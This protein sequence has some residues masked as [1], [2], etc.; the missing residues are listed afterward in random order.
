MA[1]HALSWI[2][3]PLLVLLAASTSFAASRGAWAPKT[4]DP[5][6]GF[7][8]VSL[9]ES[10]FVLQRPF[11]EASG[12][13]YSFNGTVRKLWVL[14]SD[15][16]HARQSHTSP[17]TE[18]RMAGYD[19]SSGVW[20]F[21]GY[22]Y[23]PSGTTGV[24]IMQVFGAGETATTLMLHVY[25]G[26]LRYYDR[27]IVEDAIYDR[28]F[29]LN[30]VH[31]VEGSTLTVYIDGQQRLHVDGRGGDSHYFKFGVYAQNHDSSCMESRWKGVR[32]L[33][34]DTSH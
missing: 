8:A 9:H 6:D 10:N 27:Q 22:G 32:I 11:D 33:K 5:D 17:R 21:E 18:I 26:A 25:D 13:R 2:S 15:K 3:V 19:Y 20:Q 30:V 4:A 7:T 29:R 12:A 23:V 24:S 16:P 1:P 28:W 14:S 31:D 34:K